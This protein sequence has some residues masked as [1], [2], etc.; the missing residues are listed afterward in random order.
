MVEPLNLCFSSKGHE[1]FALQLLQQ[2]PQI[3]YASGRPLASLARVAWLQL[4]VERCSAV[5]KVLNDWL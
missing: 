3:A 4:G 5:E 1:D 2:G